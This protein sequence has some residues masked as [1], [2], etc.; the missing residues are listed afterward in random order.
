MGMRGGSKGE[1]G[2]RA[3]AVQASA[4]AAPAPPVVSPLPAVN[5]S[6][7]GQS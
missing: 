3:V 6:S 7:V 5:V 2:R 4:V 1:G